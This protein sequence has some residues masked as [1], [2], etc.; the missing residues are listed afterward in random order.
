MTE[1]NTMNV[2]Y[3][4]H[5]LI[6]G[7][8]SGIGAALA[9]YYARPGIHIT[10]WGRNENRLA[11]IA[12][13]VCFRG[14]SV[15]TLSLDITDAEKALQAFSETDQKNPVD[16]LILSAGMSDIRPAGHKTESPE[17]A[18]KMSMVNFATPVTLAT[19]A[20]A[21]MAERGGG[22]IGIMG[23]VASFHD[24]PLATV[25]SGSKAGVGR[26]STALRAAVAPYNVKVT[27]IAPGFVDTPMS[28]KLEGDQFFLV[29]VDV[30]A[31]KIAR[32]INRGQATLVFPWV[33]ELTRLLEMVLPRAL[34]HRI[35]R[36]LDIMQH[37][38][39]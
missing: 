35:L 38:T 13:K 31:R 16:I 8:S 9:L 28:Q 37:P 10:L 11:D 25:Y 36:K 20:A 34:A 29:P 17:I 26:F 14:A 32:A 4:H 5:V 7:G 30:A 24:L 15:S 12:E 39:P 2:S 27:L 3:R 21:L 22:R 33:F 19:K 1:K 6:T 18:L 23:S